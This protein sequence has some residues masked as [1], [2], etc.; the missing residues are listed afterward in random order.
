LYEMADYVAPEHERTAFNCP[1]CGVFSR[2]TFMGAMRTMNSGRFVGALSEL[3]DF[4][5]SQCDH[6]DRY[7]IWHEQRLIYPPVAGGPPAHADT[8]EDVAAD[9]NEA[10]AVMSASPRSSAALLRLALQKLMVHVGGKG[11]NINEDIGELVKRGLDPRIQRALD[12]VR[13]SG[14]NAVHAGELDLRDDVPIVSQLFRLVNLVVQQMIT[15]PREID[16]LWGKMPEGAREGVEK[17]DR[18]KRPLDA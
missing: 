1:W 8:P 16:E 12:I 2:Q 5:I 13:I 15:Q 10:R 6:C 9:Y 17:R 18:S 3:P 7:A 11:S 14:N 4:G